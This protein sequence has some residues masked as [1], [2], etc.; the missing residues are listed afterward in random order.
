MGSVQPKTIFKILT[1]LMEAGLNICK[2][3]QASPFDP[4]LGTAQ[5]QLVFLYSPFLTLSKKELS[6]SKY[7]H[8]ALFTKIS[9]NG[10]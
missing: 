5:P 8:L 3:Q 2:N 1:H 10:F 9:D 4:E 6:Y 7:L